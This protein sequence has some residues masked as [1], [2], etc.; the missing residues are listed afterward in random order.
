MHDSI[1]TNHCSKTIWNHF[2][3]NYNTITNYIL[4]IYELRIFEYVLGVMSQI[5]V[6]GV[7]VGNRTDDPHANSLAQYLL[8]YQGILKPF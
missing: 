7:S 1:D 8:D 6:S 2:I 4:I 3:I 5:L